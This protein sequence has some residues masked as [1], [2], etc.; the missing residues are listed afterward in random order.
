MAD[1][2][3]LP[4][5]VEQAR[6]SSLEIRRPETSLLR[7]AELTLAAMRHY[8]ARGSFAALG[9]SE[10]VSKSKKQ[11][12][13]FLNNDDWE[14]FRK[15][16]TEADDRSCAILFAAYIDNCLH[17]LVASAL[18]HSDTTGKDLLGD[19]MPLGTLSAKTKIAHCLN[20]IPTSVYKDINHIRAVRNLFAHQLHGL[21][22]D[23][24]PIK[25]IVDKLTTPE[26]YV[27]DPSVGVSAWPPRER[28]MLACA[29]I[30]STCES[31]YSERA[32][33]VRGALQA[34]APDFDG[35]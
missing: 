6:G 34:V 15:E 21:S 26:D 5:L 14:K 4:H 33:Q 3:Q 11:S 29:A 35:A 30:V 17:V 31:Y 20:L 19:M 10:R 1:L 9:E 16:H 25:G 13:E 22:F 24:A 32:K 28:F 8:L 18:L 12:K 7:P 23:K 27:S 2:N